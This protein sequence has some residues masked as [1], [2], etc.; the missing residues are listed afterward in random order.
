[1]TQALAPKGVSRSSFAHGPSI[2]RQLAMQ[3]RRRRRLGSNL[4]IINLCQPPAHVQLHSGVGETVVLCCWWSVVHHAYSHSHGRVTRSAPLRACTCQNLGCSQAPRSP[5]D[6]AF[7]TR[8][9]AFSLTAPLNTLQTLQT[10][11]T[12]RGGAGAL[13]VRTWTPQQT[14][15]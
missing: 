14:S 4:T 8:Q 3:G 9:A 15:K 7:P 5:P 1:M 11:T 10:S 13:S 12:R 6:F 2:C